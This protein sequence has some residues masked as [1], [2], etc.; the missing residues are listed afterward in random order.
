[1]KLLE[2]LNQR[3]G[4][5]RNESL[6]VLFLVGSLVVG[7]AVKLFKEL[8]GDPAGTYDY[9]RLD[10]EFVLRSQAAFEQ[11]GL[12]GGR[13]GADSARPRTP[14]HPSAGKLKSPPEKKININTA[15]KQVLM[16]LPGIGETTAERILLY[17]QDQGPFKRID[18]LQEVK[19]IGKKKLERLVPYVTA[20]EE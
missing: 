7:G 16:R 18:D 10:Q 1:M 14:I 12:G 8:A 5:T 3:M 13:E 19:G 15:T 6:V 17:R 11:G 2:R 4:F 20:G 9:S